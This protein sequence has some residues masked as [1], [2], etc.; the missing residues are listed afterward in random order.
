MVI[1]LDIETFKTFRKVVGGADEEIT[2]ATWKNLQ[3]KWTFPL[4]A[5]NIIFDTGAGLGPNENQGAWIVDLGRASNRERGISRIVIPKPAMFTGQGD[6]ILA[7]SLD[8]IIDPVTIVVPPVI[9]PDVNN[10]GNDLIRKLESEDGLLWTVVKNDGVVEDLAATEVKPGQILL[11]TQALILT[12]DD[13]FP[14]PFLLFNRND[15][16]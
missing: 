12:V 5:G 15:I 1:F 3:L 8:Y 10:D 6:K 9:N 13:V 16:A 11:L 4:D 7:Y 14:A 2:N